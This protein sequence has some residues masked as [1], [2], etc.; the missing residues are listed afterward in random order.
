[1]HE[2]VELAAEGVADLGEDTV[3][4]RVVPDVEL[5]DERARDRLRQLAH[6]LLDALA[7]ER[8]RDLGAAVGETLGDR[9]G[10]RPLVRDSQD[11]RTLPLEHGRRL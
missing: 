9:P 2:D 8:E 3:D 6:V 4:R 1:M 5:G 11:E 7:L 10:D